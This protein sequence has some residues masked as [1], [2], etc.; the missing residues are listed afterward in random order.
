MFK[1]KQYRVKHKPASVDVSRNSW[2]NEMQALD[3]DDEYKV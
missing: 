2:G 3:N 1:L